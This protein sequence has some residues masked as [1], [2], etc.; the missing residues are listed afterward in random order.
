MSIRISKEKCIGCKK[1]STVCPGSLIE[2]C[3]GKAEIKYPEDCWGCASCLKECQK[4]AIE[5]F[6]GEDIGGNGTYMQTEKDGTLLHWKFF[7]EHGLIRTI[8][9]DSTNSNKY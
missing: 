9:V 3:G 8:T 5:F 1:C 7:D 6:L 2:V 4:G